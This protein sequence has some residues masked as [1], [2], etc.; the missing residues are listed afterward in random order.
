MNRRQFLAASVGTI[1]AAPTLGSLTGDLP[2][3]LPGFE[4]PA[5]SPLEIKLKV[6]PVMFN[7][8]HSGLWEGPC[9]WRG[10]SPA[11]ERRLAEESFARWCKQLHQQGLGRS[12][13]VH[14][15]PPAHLTFAEDFRIPAEEMNK[16]AAD[17]NQTDV[18]FL[19]PAGSSICGYEVAHR[20]QKP[21]LLR[22]L[23][24]RNVDI[25]A[26]VRAR[27]LEA[28]VAAHDGELGEILSLLRARKV[29]QQTRVLFPT[30]RGLPA[31]CSCG[32]I[33]DLAELE[34]RLKVSVVTISYK[35]LTEAMEQVLADPLAS[36]QAQ[37]AAETLLEKA[38]RS[39]IDKKYV[40]RSMQFYKAVQNLMRRHHCNAFTIECFEF[41]S[42]RLPARWN[43]TPCL[44]HALFR[45][46]S[47]ASSCEADLG[48]LLAL[49]MLMSVSNKSCHQGNSDPGP[50]GTFT[51]NHSSSS[52]KMAGFD[53]PDTPYQLGRF[54][55]EGW[56]T[57]VVLNFM[58]IAEAL[59]I[60]EK[61]VTL[62]RVNPL[63]NKLLVLRGNLVGST[64]WDQDLLGCS[65]VAV[66]RPPQGRTDEFLKKRLEYGNHLQWVFGDYSQQLAQLGQM[67][68]LQ[69]ELI[70]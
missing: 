40:I 42:S 3:V 8:I 52:M 33:W 44:L 66:I 36:Q 26:Y 18:Y 23:G 53:Q 65:V 12:E 58:Q 61:I 7:L 54:V 59:K 45:N 25:A 22:G 70:T 60:P 1:S 20:F 49:R 38:H 57:K 64:G 56:G 11:E 16:L 17:A 63:A 31:V 24:C 19:Y 4:D 69:V 46:R 62:A 9:R 10:L 21:I 55:S 41:C 50:D 30:D 48:S 34:K 43:I 32:S 6:K 13:D 28:Y 29:F 37:Q 47:F 35:E 39:F 27:G 15:L 51:I 2:A 5:T 68:G 14:L 67:L